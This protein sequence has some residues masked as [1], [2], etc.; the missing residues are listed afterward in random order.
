[1]YLLILLTTIGVASA[2]FNAS[3]LYQGYRY[4]WRLDDAQCAYTDS[5]P[6][7]QFRNEDTRQYFHVYTVYFNCSHP[8][9]ICDGLRCRPHPKLSAPI[10][11]CVKRTWSFGWLLAFALVSFAP[12]ILVYGEDCIVHG[13]KSNSYRISE[14]V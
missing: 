14:Y 13:L 2:T 1:M 8:G 4:Y 7:F 6:V 12:P 11:A 5:Q 3:V 9:E 10:G